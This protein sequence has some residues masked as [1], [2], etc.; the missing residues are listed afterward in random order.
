[1]FEGR[2]GKSEQGGVGDEGEEDLAGRRSARGSARWGFSRRAAQGAPSDPLFVYVPTPPPPKPAP[3]GY[4]EGPCGLAV[5]STGRFY[6]SDYYHHAI[7][8]FSP[9]SSPFTEPPSFQGQLAN[10]DPL[11]GPCALPST[12]PTTSTSTTSTA[13]S[14]GSTPRLPSARGRSSPA[15]ASTKPTPPGVAVDPTTGHIYVDDRTYVAVYESSG[16]RWKKAA[17]RCTSAKAACRKASAW[18]SR[19]FGATAGRLYVPDAADQHGQGL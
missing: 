9:P 18:R 16:A 6:V 12:P 7:D 8:V 10:E 5:D 19:E 4:L 17:N 2:R 1:M 11:D 14:S 15:P 13:T 3:D